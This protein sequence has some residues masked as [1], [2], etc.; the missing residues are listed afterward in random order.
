ME[1]WPTA[2]V[3]ELVGG[4]VEVYS[5]ASAHVHSVPNVCDILARIRVF[6]STLSEHLARKGGSVMKWSARMSAYM[7]ETASVTASC[8]YWFREG[9]RGDGVRGSSVSSSTY[10]VLLCCK[11]AL[12]LLVRKLERASLRV[13]G[14]FAASVLSR[15][16]F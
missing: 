15:F 3:L 10:C 6:G 8:R 16:G 14:T 1:C 11:L 7:M 4:F 9:G 13:L 2:C 5:A 12:P